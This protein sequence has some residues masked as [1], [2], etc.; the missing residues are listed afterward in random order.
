M[1]DKELIDRFL[2]GEL[3]E[4]GMAQLEA[5]LGA[6]PELLRELAD[7][8]QMEHALRILLGDDTSDQ[9]VAVSVLAVLR[10]PSLDAFKTDL[11]KKVQAED[12]RQR[13]EDSAVRVR[14]GPVPRADAAPAED[15]PAAATRPAAAVR[16]PRRLRPLLWAGAGLGA[17]AAL[18]VTALALLSGGPGVEPPD[19]GA[20]VLA[21]GA[22]VKVE[23]DGASVAARMDMGLKAGD[24][25]SVPAGA[26]AKIGFADDTTR[27]DLQGPAQLVFLHGGRRK[28][29]DLVR[30]EAELAV[31]AQAGGSPLRVTTPHSELEA[32]EDAS[33]R[34]QSAPDF[35]RLEVRKGAATLVR[36]GDRK[37]VRV[38]A[39]QY[40]VAGKDLEL[41][42][43]PLEPLKATPDG[44]AVVA[45]LRKVQG[46]VYLFTQSPADRVPAKAGQPVREDQGIVTEGPRSSAAVDYPDTTRLE[47]GGDTV[48]RRL[49]ADKDRLRKHVLLESG[50]LQA[51]VVKQPVG[52]SMLLTTAQAEANVIGTRFALSSEGDATRLQVE[53]GAVQF[54]QRQERWTIVVRSG[55]YAVAAPGRPFEALPA[56]GGVRYLDIDLA[57]GVGDAQGDWK[58]DGRAVRQAR[59]SADASASSFLVKAESEESVLLEAVA[60]VDPVAPGGA[61]G[62]GFGLVAAFGQENLVLRTL[63]GAD[64][65]SVF[66]FKDAA[67]IP[68]EHG[69]EG[70]YRLKL[71]IERRGKD[72]P[73]LLRGKIWQGDREPDGWMIENE[74]PL[75]GPVLQV[76]FQTVRCACTFTS[77]KV[78]VL[79]DEPR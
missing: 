29:V 23:R 69:R 47:V 31:A 33:L 22:G 62:W 26:S 3:D 41:A 75:R 10:A 50:Q 34:L 55:F 40:A 51:D 44:P 72:Q 30:G 11:M 35:T 43:K 18:A 58:V 20:F 73:A 76:G 70:T 60:E 45:H 38:G 13:R 7:Q 49:V 36:R 14:T 77:F 42:A 54:T 9:Q 59:A 28:L 16:A 66:E 5:E 53:E 71:R 19:P 48:L 25:L 56:P 27:I 17:A 1:T 21:A 8:R 63:Q 2:T 24:R 52:R 67:A 32:S 15:R 68:F 65:G 39:D 4:A 61:S 46:Q 57:S 12:A 64:G 74:R 79:G 37:S 78:K 6:H